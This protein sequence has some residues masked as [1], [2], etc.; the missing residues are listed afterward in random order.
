MTIAEGL[1]QLKEQREQG[2][3]TQREF[4]TGAQKAKLL[5][6]VQPRIL[7]PKEAAFYEEKGST[8]KTTLLGIGLLTSLVIA[9]MMVLAGCSNVVSGDG[10][11]IANQKLVK[12]GDSVKITGSLKNKLDHTDSIAV[13]WTL[14]DESHNAVASHFIY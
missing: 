2:V 14:Y 10:F 13:V 11:E 9:M 4:D 7:G 3:L 1:S 5:N 8:M 12:E 6:A